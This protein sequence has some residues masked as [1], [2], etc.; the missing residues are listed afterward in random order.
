MRVLADDAK[1]QKS[2]YNFIE[3]VIGLC[4]IQSHFYKEKAMRFQ[5]SFDLSVDVRHV[6]KLAII[7]TAEKVTMGAGRV[8]T[9]TIVTFL[10]AFSDDQ[11]LPQYFYPQGGFRP[12][13]LLYEIFVGEGVRVMESP[14]VDGQR[15]LVF[16][17][18]TDERIR[19][20]RKFLH[21]TAEKLL[22]ELQELEDAELSLDESADQLDWCEHDMLHPG[23]RGPIPDFT[24]PRHE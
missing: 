20:A 5:M 2:V 16:T 14:M 12:S 19:D 10:L 8:T 3:P 23:R 6:G 4:N 9:H 24:R 15:I 11:P 7:G 17:R 18:E 1:R 13:S 21:A 22:R